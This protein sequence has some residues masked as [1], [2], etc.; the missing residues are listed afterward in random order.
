M[1]KVNKNINIYIYK[2]NSWF[3]YCVN[4][5]PPTSWCYSIRDWY[6]FGDVALGGVGVG[7]AEFRI[8]SPSQMYLPI[9]KRKI[10]SHNFKTILIY[11]C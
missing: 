4:I 5:E 11:V 6:G 2:K 8:P 7:V 1:C 9:E 3:Q 10:I